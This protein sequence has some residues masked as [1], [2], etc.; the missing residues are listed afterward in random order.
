[1]LHQF[2]DILPSGDTWASSESEYTTTLA[3]RRPPAF[4]CL[5]STS[6]HQNT[7]RYRL[8]WHLLWCYL[9]PFFATQV[10]VFLHSHPL[11]YRQPNWLSCVL[12]K[13]YAFN[14]KGEIILVDS[15]VRILTNSPIYNTDMFGNLLN[16]SVF[17]TSWITMC[18][19]QNLKITFWY[20]I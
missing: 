4:R 16:T 9:P 10:E 8:V 6:Q 5:H 17:N 12:K 11:N 18:I 15:Y 13:T 3:L 2:K 7:K 14:E 1:M 20:F 19:N